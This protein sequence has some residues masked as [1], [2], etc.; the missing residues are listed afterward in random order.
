MKPSAHEISNQ[1]KAVPSARE[2]KNKTNIIWNSRLFFQV[3]LIIGLLATFFIMEMDFEIKERKTTAREGVTIEEPRMISYTLEKPEPVPV[4]AVP[5]KQPEPRKK[6]VVLTT[7]IT[8][9]PTNSTESPETNVAPTDQP[10]VAEGPVATTPVVPDAPKTPGSILGVEFAPVFPG[11]EAAATNEDKIA[12]MSSK[13]SAFISKKFNTEKF[14]GLDSGTKNIT[15]QFTINAAGY[16][17]DVK[18][19]ADTESLQKEASRVVEK[20]PKM[21]PGRQGIT[22]VPVL[23]SIPILFRVE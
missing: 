8:V 6:E 11:C 21:R 12:C 13:V 22:N 9:D 14:S 16:V 19:R 18:A 10:V 17:T 2:E 23:Y 5:K 7:K 3:G 4:T 15:V 1:Q 20:L